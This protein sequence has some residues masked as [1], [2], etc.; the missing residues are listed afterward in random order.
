MIKSEIVGRVA[1]RVGICRAA[2]GEAVDAMFKTVGGALTRGEAVRIV[3]FGTFGTR[4]RPARTGRN[5]RTGES[6]EIAASTTPTFKPCWQ[7]RNSVN[8][9]GVY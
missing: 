2:A 1:D 4:R 9:G 5:P 6:L 7:L 3:G 8:D